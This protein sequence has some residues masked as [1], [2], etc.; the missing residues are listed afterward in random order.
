MSTNTD[1]INDTVACAACGKEGDEANM[2]TCNKCKEAKYCN[3]VCKKNRSKHKKECEKRVVEKHDEEL[4]K[5]P[6]PDEDCPICF[7]PIP[8]L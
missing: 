2:N 4:F 6:P 8:Y 3:A 7:L 1:N 5:K